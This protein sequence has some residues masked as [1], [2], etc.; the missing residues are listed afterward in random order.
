MPTA[1]K[2]YCAHYASSYLPLT[3]NWIHRVLVNHKNFSP[4]FLTRKKLKPEIFPIPE[5]LSLDDFGKVRQLVELV[6]F[7][8][9]GYIPFFYRAC[10]QR[11]VK[12]LHVHFGY[13]G[14]K[15][16]GLKRKLKI[17]MICSFYGDDA[18]AA[19][20]KG[21]YVDLFQ[22][23]DA[24]LV[25][26]PY[27][28]S[29]LMAQGCPEEKIRIHHL[30][31]DVEKITFQQRHPEKKLRFLIAS[32]FLQKKGI[33]IAIRALAS[34]RSS[35]DFTLD[36]IGDGSMREE[37]ELLVQHSNMTEQVTWHGYKPYD[38]FIGL[39]YQCDVFIQASKTT[40]DN[41]KEGTPMAIADVMATG[42]PVV[43]TY[44]SDIPEMVSDG[45]TGYLAQ[46]NDVVS[47]TDCLQ[48]LLNNPGVLKE[49]SK[50]SRAH[51]EK[52]FSSSQQTAQ[53]EVLYQ[54]LIQKQ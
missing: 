20:H 46:E 39:A 26:G 34:L 6:F 13:H 15:M 36:I 30:G 52:H 17:P 9:F 8:T 18:F 33:D 28:K 27:M 11:D 54:S 7:R 48:K 51:V 16:V 10:K 45:V 12:I 4:V 14:A 49:F 2:T 29:V 31:I 23:A 19:L 50:N 22:Y 47:L 38:F 32:S 35:Y 21:K 37:L 40:E 43:S 1:S 41:R 24:I 25:L 3:E 42:M 44:H 53:L 5:L